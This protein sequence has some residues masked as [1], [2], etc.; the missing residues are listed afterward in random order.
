MLATVAAA[1]STSTVRKITA[2]LYIAK[3]THTLCTLF[4][5]RR[6]HCVFYSMSQVLPL[7]PSNQG[8]SSSKWG[9]LC[10]QVRNIK[11]VLLQVTIENAFRIYY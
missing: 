7:W 2:S 6:V 9:N 3:R 4:I 8:Y 5:N 10:V 1:D 11:N